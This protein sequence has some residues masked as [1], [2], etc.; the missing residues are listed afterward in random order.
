MNATARVLVVDDEAGIRKTL[1]A[2]LEQEGHTVQTAA[3]GGGVIPAV[4]A[5]Q[6]DVVILDIMLPGVDGL[7]VL[8]QLRQESSV[9]VLMLTARS[10]EADRLVGLRMGADDYV[11]KPFSPREVVARVATLL[12]RDRSGR[13]PEDQLVR[14]PR[15]AIDPGSRQ[16]WKDDVPVSLTAIEFDLLHALAAHRGRVLNRDQLIERAWGDD[17]YIDERVVDVHIRRLRVKI[18]DDPDKARMIVTVRSVGYRFEA[19]EA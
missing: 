14:F 2:Y 10:E 11:V 7:E 13:T 15:L 17:Y 6:P 18:E 4:R 5:F 1:R 9:Y 16:V 8:R 3:D 12:R 19:D